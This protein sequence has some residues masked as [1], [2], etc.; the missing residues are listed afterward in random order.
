MDKF[1]R[2]ITVEQAGEAI[3]LLSTVTTLSKQRLK[4]LMQQ[5]AVWQTVGRRTQ[6][7][8]RAKKWINVGTQLHLYYDEKVLNFQPPSPTLI[9][10]YHHYSLWYKP[11]GMLSQGSK[12][13]DHATIT[14]W[15]EKT[16]LPQ[17]NSFTVHRLDRAASG[18]ILVAHTKKAAAALS[19]LFQQRKIDKRYQIMVSGQF[20]SSKMP[21]TISQP[22][23]GRHATSHFTL[24]AYDPAKQISLLDVIVDTGRKHQIRRHSAQLGHPVVGD[25]LYGTRDANANGTLQLLAYY[26]AFTCPITG[27]GRCIDIRERDFCLTMGLN[28]V[29]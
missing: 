13:G 19:G 18:L 20:S 5:G 24:L 23:D 7:L 1:E 12:W 4:C 16:L 25:T 9:A 3:A 29:S 10:D 11:S 14:R 21:C 15:A 6:R 17:R 8:R 2:H 26:M 27:Q 28:V 22:I